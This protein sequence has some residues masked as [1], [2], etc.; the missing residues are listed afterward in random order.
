M[1]GYNQKTSWNRAR[2]S[3]TFEVVSVLGSDVRDIAGAGGQG[4]EVIAIRKK[5]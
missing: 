5:L 1:V 3:A 4:M 2:A